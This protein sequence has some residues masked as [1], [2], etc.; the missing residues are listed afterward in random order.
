ML[1]LLCSYFSGTQE[2]LYPTRVQSPAHQANL[3]FT[4]QESLGLT[5]A[6]SLT[7][8]HRVD[9]CESCWH[10][11][12]PNWRPRS[13]K[14]KAIWNTPRLILHHWTTPHVTRVIWWGWEAAGRGKDS[15]NTVR[16]QIW[17]FCLDSKLLQTTKKKKKK[18]CLH[19]FFFSPVGLSDG[20]INQLGSNVSILRQ[21][22]LNQVL[23]PSLYH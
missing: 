19:M 12:E 21:L 1:F 22:L 2:T 4:R 8:W 5:K 6:I 3:F 15:E 9:V 17:T 23:Q 11:R 16:Y 7:F 18:Y 10:I 13:V 20:R 14:G